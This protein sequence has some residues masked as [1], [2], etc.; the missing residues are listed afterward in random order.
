MT[1]YILRAFTR[2]LLVLAVLAPLI[3]PQRAQSST[4]ITPRQIDRASAYVYRSVSDRSGLVSLDAPS[5]WDDIDETGWIVDGEVVGSRM[6]IA[7]NVTTFDGSWDAPGLV[8]S[9]S[10]SLPATMGLDEAI[11]LFDRADACT[12]GGQTSG[13]RGAFRTVTQVWNEC[14]DAN[15]GITVVGLTPKAGAE[16]YLI[17]EIYTVTAID[18][19]AKERALASLVVNHQPL[20]N[21]DRPS[22]QT[23]VES[24]GL[25]NQYDQMSDRAVVAL[26]PQHYGDRQ[27]ALW[28]DPLG[29]RIGL[30]VTAAPNIARFQ[31]SWTAPGA[32]IRTGRNF[33]TTVDVDVA[34]RDGSIAT[35]C[36]FDQRVTTDHTLFDQTWAIAYDVYRDCGGTDN[37][38]VLGIAQS[39]PVGNVVTFD[40]QI[41]DEFDAEAF[42]IFLRSFY[43]PELPPMRRDQATLPT[44]T[45]TLTPTHTPT[46]THTPTL[47]PA[48]TRTPTLTPTH[49]QTPTHTPTRTPTPRPSATASATAPT[50]PSSTATVLAIATPTPVATATATKTPGG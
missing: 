5:A 28:R 8:V 27:Q 46:S 10:A 1:Q 18:Q 11:S 37:T 20:N 48:P 38:Y 16:Y 45:P 9:R 25:A 22:L 41:I 26:I 12:D 29:R 6:V 7:R 15:S 34:L 30:T 31:Q 43:M 35:S 2:S 40:F 13:A 36:I 24:A 33:T 49:T 32:V 4:E 50:A 23:V 47:T 39:E 3:V 42:D 19:E 44:P 14:G 17:L 21:A